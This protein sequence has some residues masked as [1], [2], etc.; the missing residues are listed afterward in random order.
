MPWK[1]VHPMDEKLLFIADCL[2]QR[3]SIS[4][5]CRRCAISRKTGY[6]WLKRYREHQIEGL[7]P[8][9]SRPHH[10]PD[11][12]PV[13]IRQAIAEFRQSSFETRGAKK[14]QY[15][16]AQRFG[17]QAV[18]SKTTIYKILHELELVP[19]QKARRRRCRTTAP[20]PPVN[21]PNDLWTVDFKGQ[22][23]IADGQCVYPLT[24]MD[25]HSRFLLE[26]QALTG[27]ALR[28]T[29]QAFTRL[30]K[31]YGLPAR[32]R[33]DNGVPFA[34]NSVAGISQLSRWWIE[35][36]IVPERIAPG[37]LQQNGCHERMHRTLKAAACQSPTLTLKQQQA[38]F[39]AFR[40]EY[41]H[42]R[43]HESLDQS[44]PADWYRESTRP[45]PERIP[46]LEY[47]S[48][49]RVTR[50]KTNGV[51][52]LNDYCV[53]VGSVL[54]QRRVGMEA[55]GEDVWDFY[56]GQILLGRL[57]CKHMKR[58]KCRYHSLKL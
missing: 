45:L 39:D 26:C 52:Y 33:S 23:S 17:E 55:V 51:I 37:R 40:H 32:I 20:F 28:P 38:V 3:D 11:R 50:V 41:N 13:A 30:F 2:A 47:P 31:R 21:Q 34:S 29:K 9:S 8:R 18:P 24:V 48:W 14:I 27:P 6:K 4:A 12:V 25:H 19:K 10:S 53:Y 46:K 7:H 42:Q 54:K 43:P 58:S 22:F 57:D 5:L 49:F 35:L 1:E 56:Y 36:A 15:F 44:L 16:L